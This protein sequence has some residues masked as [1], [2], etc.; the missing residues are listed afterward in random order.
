M[1]GPVAAAMSIAMSNCAGQALAGGTGLLSARARAVASIAASPRGHGRGTA[2]RPR[3][4]SH[5]RSQRPSGRW[6]VSGRSSVCWRAWRW[7]A[8]LQRDQ[9]QLIREAP[10]MSALAS[11]T[12][13]K[14]TAEHLAR[15]AFLYVRQ[16]TLRQVVQEHGIDATAVRAASTRD[17]GSDGPRSRSW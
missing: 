12:A 17:R 1:T 14:V 2:P 15:T 4:R 7:R 13:G 10:T 11:N 16:S 6:S 5:R 8:Q 3:R 9:Q